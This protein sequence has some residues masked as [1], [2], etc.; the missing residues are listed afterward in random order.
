MSHQLVYVTIIARNDFTGT[1]KRE[2]KFKDNGGSKVPSDNPLIRPWR[3]YTYDQ[4]ALVTT[5]T[6][7]R[8]S[9]FVTRSLANMFAY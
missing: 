4:V 1:I 7:R 9:D 2:K 3:S 8:S 5:V 6:R